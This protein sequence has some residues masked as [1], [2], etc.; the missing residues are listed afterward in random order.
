MVNFKITLSGDE[1]TRILVALAS[2]EFL[3][4]AHDRAGARIVAF[5]KPYPPPPPNSSYRRTQT[6]GR[7]WIVAPTER[8]LFGMRT[9][10]GNNTVYGPYVQSEGRQAQV[11]QGRWQTDADAVRATANDI[12]ADFVRTIEA[13]IRNA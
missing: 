6:L 2:P 3:R 1:V 11:H 5:M 12:L 13:R 8:T 10:I 9:I 7:R 4:P